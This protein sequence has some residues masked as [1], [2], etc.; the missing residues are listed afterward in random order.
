MD[1]VQDR[2]RLV[3]NIRTME[4][5]VTSHFSS[6]PL[7]A[8]ICRGLNK[9]N[10]NCAVKI[11]NHSGNLIVKFKCHLKYRRLIMSG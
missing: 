11:V 2:L 8:Q 1:I 10:Q 6:I 5:E 4:E 3:L 9:S 7:R